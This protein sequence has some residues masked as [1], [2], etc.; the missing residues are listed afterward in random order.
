MGR[1]INLLKVT[2]L[3]SGSRARVRNSV[4]CLWRPY[5]LQL[6]SARMNLD[7]GTLGKSLK[8]SLSCWKNDIHCLLNF[9][10]SN[11]APWEGSTEL[12]VRTQLGPLQL[13][14]A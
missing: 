12:T 10:G 3:E 2:Q 1:L 7:F 5:S 4:I 13:K 14:V 6:S 11:K 8:S 9:L